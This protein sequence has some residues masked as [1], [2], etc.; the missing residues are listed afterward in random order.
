MDDTPAQDWRQRI[1]TLLADILDNLQTTVHHLGVIA[2]A[3]AKAAS[4]RIGIGSALFIAAIVGVFLSILFFSLALWWAI[5]LL[6]GNAWSG[7]IVGVFWI[8]ASAALIY[9][10]AR[11]IAGTRGFPQTSAA[12]H[13][14][15]DEIR[16]A[17]SPDRSASTPRAEEPG[18]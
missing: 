2:T 7:L 5:G 18:E 16:G 8:I 10:G 15:S 6:I 17:G 11:V 9:A 4:V 13:D 12:I 1:R 3:E 14:I